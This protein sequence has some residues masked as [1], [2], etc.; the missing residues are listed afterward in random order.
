LSLRKMTKWQYCN[1]DNFK[2]LWWCWSV[3]YVRT[4]WL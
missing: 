1:A 4:W 2:T 3:C